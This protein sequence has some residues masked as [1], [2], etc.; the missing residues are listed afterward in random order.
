[1]QTSKNQ[2]QPKLQSPS[3]L[4][5]SPVWSGSFPSITEAQIQRLTCKSIVFSFPDTV[6]T[7]KSA[8]HYVS[9]DHL[10]LP[11]LWNVHQQLR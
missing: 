9:R 8:L 10:L 5:F 4:S 1:M 2:S 6:E 3:C 7:Y 11:A